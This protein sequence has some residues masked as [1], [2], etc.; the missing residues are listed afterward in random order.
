MRSITPALAVITIAAAVPAGTAGASARSSCDAWTKS[1]VSWIFSGFR[2]SRPGGPPSSRG[3]YVYRQRG[4]AG[5]RPRIRG[6]VLGVPVASGA[7]VVR[8]VHVG[9]PSCCA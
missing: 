1:H 5:G 3:T 9:G 7:E 8:R 4:T 6:P 2:P